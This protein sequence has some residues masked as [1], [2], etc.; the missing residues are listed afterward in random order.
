MSKLDRFELK[1]TKKLTLLIA[2]V[3]I[4]YYAVFTL[5]EFLV[6]DNGIIVAI[7]GILFFSSFLGIII[8]AIS[9]IKRYY[10]LLFSKEG[11]IRLSF[12]V[13]NS[14]HLKTNIRCGLGKIYCLAVIFAFC[15]SVSEKVYV[16][17]QDE[18]GLWGIFNVYSTYLDRYARNNYLGNYIAYPN[19]RALASVIISVLALMVLIETIYVSSIFVLTVAC[20]ICGKYNILQ[21]KG[22]IF[23]ATIVMYN[24]FLLISNLISIFRVWLNE[25]VLGVGVRGYELFGLDFVFIS[26]VDGFVMVILIG[27]ISSI[28][29]YRICKNIL[30]TKLD[31]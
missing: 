9:L 23:I 1:E 28:V 22:V 25:P 21:K 20:R 31:I 12:P 30:D 3:M 24:V 8:V 11:F 14:E 2:C 17:V 15:L 29:M 10:D 19:L 27:V 26:A 7:S 4:V 5:T 6:S 18:H 16:N 13:K